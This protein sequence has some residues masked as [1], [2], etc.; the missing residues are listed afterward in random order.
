MSVENLKRV[1]ILDFGDEDGFGDDPH[2]C[3]YCGENR[4]ALTVHEESRVVC[5]L[6]CGTVQSSV[7][8]E[9]YE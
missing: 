1:E 8:W 3:E 2:I 7:Y 9:E 4:F 6:T 5:C